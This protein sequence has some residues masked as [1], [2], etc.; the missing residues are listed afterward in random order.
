MIANPESSEKYSQ[1]EVE[2][3]NLVKIEV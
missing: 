1:D 3:D 2:K